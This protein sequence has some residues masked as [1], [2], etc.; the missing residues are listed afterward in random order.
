MGF[1]V[2]DSLTLCHLFSHILSL[3]CHSYSIKIRIFISKEN[4]RK[5]AKNGHFIKEKIISKG[6]QRDLFVKILRGTYFA[7]MAVSFTLFLIGCRSY[8]GFPEMSGSLEDSKEDNVFISEFIAPQNPYKINDTL[9]IN[10][11]EAWLEHHWKYTKSGKV[12]FYPGYQLIIICDRENIKQYP[13]LWTIGT[14]DGP[15]FRSCAK[16]CIMA[17]FDDQPKESETWIVQKGMLRNNQTPEVIGNFRL[18]KKR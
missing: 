14:V 11:K 6:M 15:N 2:S 10:V 12:V 9:S 17:D 5:Q 8:D 1:F 7:L 16:D 3:I 13:F 18:I 4:I